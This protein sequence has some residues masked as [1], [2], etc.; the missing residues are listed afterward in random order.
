MNSYDLSRVF[1]DFSFNNPELIKP[2]H[3]AVFFFAIEH[4]NRLGWKDKFGFPTTMVMEAI[5][6]KSYNT[7]KSTLDD[8]VKF[9]FIKMIE[10]AKNQWSSNIIAI[11]KNDKAQYKALDKALIKHGTKQSES[12]EQSND[13]IDKQRT[14]NK[15]QL[16]KETIDSIFSFSD[17]WNLYPNKVA[18]DKCID[19]YYKLSL[20]EIQKIKDTIFNFIKY[21]PFDSY[22]HPNPE[23]Y[24]NQKRWNDEIGIAEKKETLKNVSNAEFFANM[25]PEEKEKWF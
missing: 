16:N 2:N 15:E 22:N 9:G 17:F 25:S 20:S 11:S 5:G 8:L 19:K 18:K 7:Y 1:W 24:I 6:I 23:T 14:K 12:T 21:K 4:C 10:S 13:S 3:C